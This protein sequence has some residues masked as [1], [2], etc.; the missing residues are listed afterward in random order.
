MDIRPPSSHPQHSQ[1]GYAPAPP[2]YAYPSQP[3]PSPAQYGHPSQPATSAGPATYRPSMPLVMATWRRGLAGTSVLAAVLLGV[4]LLYAFS[5]GGWAGVLV[6]AALFIALFVLILG[7]WLLYLRTLS[8]TVDEGGVVRRV[9]G[10][11]RRIPRG[12]L[13]QAVLCSYTQQSRFTWREVPLVSL[14]DAT[15]RSRLTLNLSVWAESDAQALVSRL[16]LMGRVSQAGHRDIRRLRREIPG[17][18]PW[19]VEH[20]ALTFLI[21]MGITLAVVVAVVV[22]VVATST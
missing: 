22:V 3:S 5:H 2:Q 19:P 11:G 21:T 9:F 13:Q 1:G 15:G 12:L 18:L 6:T 20:R 17:A 14:L 16:G 4:R 10:L 8:L 7:I